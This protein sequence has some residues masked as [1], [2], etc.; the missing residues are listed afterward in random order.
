MVSTRSEAPTCDDTAKVDSG[1]RAAVVETHASI[2]FDTTRRDAEVLR[3]VVD[4]TVGLNA[5][6]GGAGTNAN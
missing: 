3:D 5:D 2:V 6:Y 1:E 4:A